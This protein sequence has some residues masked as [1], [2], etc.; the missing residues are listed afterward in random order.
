MSSPQSFIRCVNSP[1]FFLFMAP[2][3][4]TLEWQTPT[5]CLINFTLFNWTCSINWCLLISSVPILWNTTLALLGSD[6]PAYLVLELTNLSQY[7]FNYCTSLRVKKGAN[8]QC[9]L[10]IYGS[11]NCIGLILC[12]TW[13]F[14]I[15]AWIMGCG[16]PHL[17][18]RVFIT[19]HLSSL[20]VYYNPLGMYLIQYRIY[21]CSRLVKWIV[22]Y[23]GITS[24]LSIMN[25]MLL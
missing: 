23:Y 1:P 21:I 12:F 6:S 11:G 24:I 14:R 7:K 18:F 15:A 16:K 8:L 4:K 19:L 9:L 25:M 2:I 10:L 3:R 17:L 13:C 22:I 20:G 5:I